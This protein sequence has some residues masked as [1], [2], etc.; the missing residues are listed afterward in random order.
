MRPSNG[1]SFRGDCNAEP[2]SAGP[3]V[4]I[5]FE[6]EASTSAGSSKVASSPRP[7]PRAMFNTI[8]SFCP[9]V[10]SSRM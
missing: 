9:M 6:F 8:K 10:G 1:D 3:F 4:M 5:S 7:S 2:S